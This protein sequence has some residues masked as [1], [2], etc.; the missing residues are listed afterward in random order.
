MDHLSSLLLSFFDWLLEAS[1]MASV[2][3]GLI[4]FVKVILRNK[5]SPRWHYMLW[6]V[7]IVRLLLPWAPESSFSVYNLLPY[8]R[9]TLQQTPDVPAY[10]SAVSPDH[11]L[12]QHL[13]PSGVSEVKQEPLSSVPETKEEETPATFSIYALAFYVWLLGVAC[14]GILTAIVNWRFYRQI[15]QRPVLTDSKMID[16]LAQCKK[17]MSIKQSI[18]LVPTGKISSPAV[19]GFIRP[20][21]ILPDSLIRTLDDHQLRII[22]YHEL[23]HV[24]RKDVAVNWLMNGLLILHWF[25]PLLWYAYHKMR[26]D[27]EIACDA[28]ALTFIGMEQK[29]FYGHTVISLLEHYSN[30]RPMPSLATLSG[31]KKQLRRRIL[32][33]KSFQKKSYRWS[34]LG[35]AS[36]IAISSISLVNAKELTPK[37]QESAAVN[38]SSSTALNSAGLAKVEKKLTINELK[39]DKKIIAS[40]QE[41]LRRFLGDSKAELYE[42][43]DTDVS[44]DWLLD[45]KNG[46]GRVAINKQT[47]Q[48]TR[49]E[50]VYKWNE[51]SPAV[52][53]AAINAIH[54]LDSK[55]PFTAETIMKEKNLSGKQQWHE[56]TLTGAGMNVILNADTLKVVGT[57]ITYPFAQGDKKA[58]AAGLNALQVMNGGKPVPVA[59]DSAA[60]NYSN[61]SSGQS[62][63]W[64]F[65]DKGGLYVAEVGAKTGKI[66]YIYMYG[67]RQANEA[68]LTPI[69]QKDEKRFYTKE[70]AIAKAKPMVKKVFGIDLTGYQ[71]EFGTENVGYL[72]FKKAGQPTIEADVDRTGEFWSYFV[73]PANGMRD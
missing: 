1:M 59:P 39:L 32:M 14:I 63:V 71:V 35:L 48:I 49:L 55:K 66:R 27:Q 6:L 51:L 24:K 36:L 16:L 2:L 7:I 62:D 33:I 60:H 29:E 38:M 44:P 17:T 9:E 64:R 73:I 70:Q 58:A 53:E 61:T 18:P 56:W 45:N 4:L 41:E 11:D 31:G 15:K 28:L 42:V 46:K 50:A 43:I 3:V 13:V 8:V 67:K 37:A 30:I 57:S 25:N 52:K 65:S 40:A 22:F 21:I 34:T 12:Q 5:L 69:P 10:P 26:E 47:G 68:K 20:R 23:A 72:V 54:R 19:L